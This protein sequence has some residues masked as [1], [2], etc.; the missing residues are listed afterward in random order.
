MSKKKGKPILD[1]ACGGRMFYFDKNDPRVLFCDI[2]NFETELCDGRHFEV[3]PDVQCDFTA[4]PFDDNT[5]RVVVFDPPHLTRNTGE[6]KYKTLYG[7]LHPKAIA[8]QQ[9]TN[10]SSTVGWGGLAGDVIKG[11]C[12]M[13]PRS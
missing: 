8:S 6:S 7:S 13:L 9:G 10:K 3:K 1:V 2:R 5:Y 11:L 4:L 12:G